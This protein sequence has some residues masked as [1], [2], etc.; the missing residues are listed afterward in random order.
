MYSYVHLLPF[1]ILSMSF[2]YFP[3]S[4]CG[5]SILTAVWS[6]SPFLAFKNMLPNTFLYISS[7]EHICTHFQIAVYQLWYGLEDKKRVCAGNINLGVLIEVE[8]IRQGNSR[9]DLG[10]SHCKI[11]KLSLT[12]QFLVDTISYC[13]Q[14]TARTVTLNGSLRSPFLS[15]SLMTHLWFL[16]VGLPNFTFFCLCPLPWKSCIFFWSCPEALSLSV[17]QAIK[18]PIWNT[19]HSERERKNNPMEE[20]L[21]LYGAF[22]FMYYLFFLTNVIHVCYQTL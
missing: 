16:S 2:R 13:I 9:K 12:K 17:F 4:H 11:W 6:C 5:P 1:K 21:R 7:G 10:Q 14:N 19:S 15:V 20:L 22:E 3:R 8:V 18:K